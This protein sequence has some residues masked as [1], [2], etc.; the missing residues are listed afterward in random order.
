MLLL[1]KSLAWALLAIKFPLL[2]SGCVFSSYNNLPI[3]FVAS[4]E[5]YYQAT[6]A[7][8]VDL[9]SLFAD[10]VCLTPPDSFAITAKSQRAAIR[11]AKLGLTFFSARP[12]RY[13]LF[14]ELYVP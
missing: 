10:Q 8:F 3:D 5:T 11:L 2:I 14:N 4:M 7:K 9:L 6:V 12:D 13:M 1:P